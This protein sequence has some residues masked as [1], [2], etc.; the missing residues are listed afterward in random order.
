MT[1]PTLLAV[2][3]PNEKADDPVALG[4]A[5]SV[6]TRELDPLAYAVTEPVVDATPLV[7][8]ADVDG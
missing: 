3:K 8:V 2:A 5:A 4:A 7:N 6:T 1:N